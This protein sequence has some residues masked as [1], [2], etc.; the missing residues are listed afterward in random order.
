MLQL[1]SVHPALLP[2]TIQL[3]IINKNNN[4]H[5]SLQQ[6]KT[7]PVWKTRSLPQPQQSVI[8]LQWSFSCGFGL[9][10]KSYTI[11]SA[12]LT[13]MICRT[14]VSSISL[15]NCITTYHIT[16]F[17][18][19]VHSEP[20]VTFIEKSKKFDRADIE[21]TVILDTSSLRKT[22]GFFWGG[23]REKCKCGEKCELITPPLGWQWRGYRRRL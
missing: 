17:R 10:K 22:P 11:S 6:I 13:R 21:K 19:C 7:L 5:R 14:T 12:I 18:R 15:I 20:G 8:K 4:H 2:I 23:I 3:M 9:Q 16:F 1:R